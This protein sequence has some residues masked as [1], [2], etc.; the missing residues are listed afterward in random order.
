MPEPDGR[1]ALDSAR[2]WRGSHMRFWEFGAAM[3]LTR[4]WLERV[5][6]VVSPSH[7]ENRGFD[8][9][10]SANDFSEL[11]ALSICLISNFSPMD[12]AFEDWFGATLR[13]S[14]RGGRR[15]AQSPLSRHRCLLI[16]MTRARIA[17]TPQSKLNLL[18]LRLCD[19]STGYFATTFLSS[20][21][22]C[23]AMQSGLCRP[24]QVCTAAIGRARRSERR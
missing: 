9:L 2:R 1:R 15:L 22:A 13:S 20:S 24:C 10:G 3:A 23:P 14:A 19:L 11:W 18:S 5:H 7:G 16:K 12:G 21:L 4:N 8:P 17:R 6:Q